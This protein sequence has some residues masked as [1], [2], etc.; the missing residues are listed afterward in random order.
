MGGDISIVI[1]LD[2]LFGMNMLMD[3]IVL[4]ITNRICRF[5]AACYRIVIAAA[6][7]ALWGTFSVIIPSDLKII[8]NICTYLL[9][10]WIMIRICYGKKKCKDILKGVLTLYVI[11]FMLGG[12]L[13]FLYY[14][15]CA[16]YVVKQIIV[17]DSGLFIFII[18]SIIL[19]VLLYAQ[20]VRIKTFADKKCSVCCVINDRKINMTGIIDTGNVLVDP[21]SH[22]PVCIAYIG[23]FKDILDEINDLTKVKYDYIPFNSVGCSK[24]LL[25]VIVVDNICISAGRKKKNINNAMVGLSHNILSKDDEYDFIVNPRIL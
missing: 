13:H 17:N 16:G 20:L 21:F 11:T 12:I 10:S 4:Y 23:H 5:T 1:Y 6:F 22:K 8:T 14:Y 7:G 25:E 15:T 2:V 19:L 24:G 18:I 3:F 9:V